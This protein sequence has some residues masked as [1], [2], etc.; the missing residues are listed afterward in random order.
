MIDHKTIQNREAKAEIMLKIAGITE[1]QKKELIDRY[2]KND[3]K[4]LSRSAQKVLIGNMFTNS[5]NMLK[6]GAEE[7]DVDAIVE[8][9]MVIMMAI[10]HNLDIVKSY[11]DHKIDRLLA[12]YFAHYRKVATE[13]GNVIVKVDDPLEKRK[14]LVEEAGEKHEKLVSEIVRLKDEGKKLYEIVKTVNKPESTV[15]YILASVDEEI[16]KVITDLKDRVEKDGVVD[17]GTGV[18]KRY[19]ISREKFNMAVKLLSNDDYDISYIKNRSKNI[20]TKILS[21]DDVW[22]DKYAEIRKKIL[23]AR[24][25][26]Q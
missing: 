19:G 13:G 7:A 1:D 12:K 4:M 9:T 22:A 17:V 14:R 23:D 26:Q 11:D 21:Q 24:I 3:G 10:N 15:R 5:V 20:G 16:R 18:E 2:A 8:H 6:K 25:Q